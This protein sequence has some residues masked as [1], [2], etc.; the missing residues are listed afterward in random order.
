MPIIPQL[1]SHLTPQAASVCVLCYPGGA[2]QQMALPPH[3]IPAT[4]MAAAVELFTMP[5]ASDD[6]ID[7]SD[8]RRGRDTANA[9]WAMKPLCWL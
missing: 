3:L 7:E 4:L 6:V 1:A 9:L 5:P 2:M 8:K